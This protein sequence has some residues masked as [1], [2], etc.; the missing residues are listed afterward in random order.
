MKFNR[1]CKHLK[2]VSMKT[3]IYMVRH[4]ES[5]YN[6]GNERTRGLT[7]KGK[8]DVEKVTEL[9]KA[10][11][12][13]III[14]SPYTRAILSVEGLAQHL[15]LDIKTFEDLRERHFVGEDYIIERAELM[16]TISEKF[17]DPDYALPGGESNTACQNRSIAVLKNIL[18]EYEGKKITI[19]THG[20]VMTLMMNHFNSNYGLDF[21]NHLKKPD[22]YKMQF[23][24]LELME[25]TRLWNE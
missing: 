22:I 13:D 25:V 24:G 17:N 10:E 5:P 7:P 19:G 2:E 23:E 18:K 6:E 12:I 1:K 4:A 14:S 3:N 9:L 20:L 15:N 21:L 8:V 11:G 16:S